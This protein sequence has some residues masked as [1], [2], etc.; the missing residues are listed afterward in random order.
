M[1]ACRP[2]RWAEPTSGPGAISSRREERQLK[3]RAVGETRIV[4]CAPALTELLHRHLEQFGNDDS[5]LLFRG[6]RG[7]Q[8]SEGT[9]CRVWRKARKDALTPAEAA[10]PLARR[11]YD[12][13]HAAVSTWL[14]AGVPST[15]VAEWAGHSVA[16]LHHIYAKCIVGQDE[17]SRR[18]IAAALDEA[19]DA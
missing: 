10:S 2:L 11:P 3:H 12:L 15:Q 16:V 17:L 1:D 5:G 6:V 9:Y 19:P 13:R 8:L 14:N 18:R 4:P 7:G